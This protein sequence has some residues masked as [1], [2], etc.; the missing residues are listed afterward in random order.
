LPRT[1]LLTFHFALAGPQ[2][3]LGLRKLVLQK[4]FTFTSLG[5]NCFAPTRLR[6]RV[7]RRRKLLR[8][9]YEPS[10]ALDEWPMALRL[11]NRPHTVTARAPARD[12]ASA[13]RLNCFQLFAQAICSAPV[14]ALQSEGCHQKRCISVEVS[15][16]R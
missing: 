6:T 14:T 9:V 11:I 16:S 13:R 4:V 7:G 12:S 10:C 1:P 5:A 3:L 8:P 15:A 2:V